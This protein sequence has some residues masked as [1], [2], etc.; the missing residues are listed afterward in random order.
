MDRD[1]APYV[2]P[3][4][5]LTRDKDRFFGR[6]REI[7]E[8]TS[9][10]LAHPITLLVSGSGAG[11]TSLVNAGLIP[12]LTG[13]GGGIPRCEVLP[14]VRF[15][16]AS[17][18][19]TTPSEPQN[20]FVSHTTGTLSGDSKQYSDGSPGSLAEYLKERKPLL[21]RVRQPL[22]RLLI[23]DQFEELYSLHPQL[24]EQR[25]PFLQELVATVDSDPLVRVLLVMREEYLAQFEQLGTQMFTNELRIRL[26][27]ERLDRP[28]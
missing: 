16:S 3:T 26:H 15:H 12:A 17:M 23:F 22:P 7:G 25:L 4:P 5:F 1:D 11:K 24:W 13:A 8:L 20:R 9:L 2:G 10:V 18:H 21:D 6:D 14:I 19:F 27:L 28:K